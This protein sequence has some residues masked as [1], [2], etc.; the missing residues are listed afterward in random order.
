MTDP[1]EAAAFVE[2]T[3]VDALAVSVGNVHTLE[4]ATAKVDLGRLGR[5]HDAVRVPLVIHGGTSFPAEAV[6]AAIQCGVAKF[7]VGTVLKRTVLDGL[8]ARVRN[9]P[10]GDSPHDL[11]GSHRPSDLLEA[12]KPLLI[13]KVRALMRLYRSS[14]RAS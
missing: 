7:N 2:A 10:V 12:T 14:G 11:L 1:G 4:A 13:A 9:L 8:S 5:I 3:D 6:P